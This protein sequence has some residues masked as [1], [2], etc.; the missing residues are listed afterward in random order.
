[1]KE[2]LEK[3]LTQNIIPFWYPATIDKERGGYHLN[4][5]TYGNPR[6]DG[7]KMI[8]TQARMVWYFSNLYKTG[9]ADK[10]SLEAAEHGFKFLRD[11]MWDRENGGFFWQLSAEGKVVKPNKHMYGQAYGL[12]SLS[13]YAIASKSRE[14]LDLARQMFELMEKHAHDKKF[15][16]YNEFFLPDWSPAT[17]AEGEYLGH[18]LKVKRMNTHLHLLEA[19]ITYFEASKDPLAKERLIE[20]IFVLSNSVVRFKVGA[21]TELYRPDWSP[22]HGPEHDRVSYGHNL[23]NI[24]LLMEACKAVGIP[25]GLLMN[26]YKTLFDYSIR[27]GFDEQKGGVYDNGPIN[28]PADHLNKT[29]WVQA[30]ALTSMFFMYLLTKEPVYLEYFEKELDW[31]EKHQIDWQN[32][33][34]LNTILPDGTPTGNKADMWKSAYHN[35]RAMINVLAALNE[36]K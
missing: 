6:K 20:L 30:E 22:V 7:E 35:G 11:R 27:F 23:E 13:E 5:D 36:F 31:I 9:W 8:V 28:R 1:M 4:H 29:W 21:C 25:N 15:G 34:W 32:G 14:A 26:Y 3:I 33:E 2:R 19:F 18:I 12:Y 10:E 17:R 24:W 16:G